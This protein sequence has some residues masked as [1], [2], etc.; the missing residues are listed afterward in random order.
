GGRVAAASSA[1]MTIAS[2]AAECIVALLLCRHLSAPPDSC[3]IRHQT[4]GTGSVPDLPGLPTPD[5][6]ARLLA[7][8]KPAAGVTASDILPMREKGV[9]HAHFRLR[10]KGLVLRVP[11]PGQAAPA[12][13]LAYQA[14]CFSR[15]APSGATPHLVATIEPETGL[16]GGA[17]LVEDIAGRVPRLPA[18]MPAIA[19]ALA[20]IHR[21]TL[22]QGAER[23]PLADHSTAGPVAAT[24][25][26]I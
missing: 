22:P 20:A 12:A 18:D 4:S 17:L 24:L 23:P 7:R 15:A 5:I 10:G 14:A 21:L 1:G 9:A 3:Q 11:R 2:G 19:E 8:Q 16:P 13:S 26:V 6:L 25:A